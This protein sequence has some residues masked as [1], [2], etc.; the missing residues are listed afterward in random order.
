MQPV[1]SNNQIDFAWSGMIEADAH[2]ITLL[3]D[4]SY[5]VAKDRFDVSIK[6]T[7]D[8]SSEIGAPHLDE[9]A[10]GHA[11]E[12]VNRE[13]AGFTTIPVN[14]AHL[15]DLITQLFN[16]T[17]Q[18]HFIGDVV[19]NSP[20]VDRITATPKMRRLL[21]E[22]HFVTAF[23]Q[24]IC[25]RRAGDAGPID[26]NS[27]TYLG[28]IQLKSNGISVLLWDSENIGLRASFERTTKSA[29]GARKGSTSIPG[30]LAENAFAS[31]LYDAPAREVYQLTFPSV[32]APA[33]RIDSR[34]GPRYTASWP[35]M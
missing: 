11:A 9:A 20:E 17:E 5:R 6:R 1:R 2:A 10:V 26:G 24:P 34:S 32:L 22:Q 31:S 12:N 3:L 29:P 15:P 4:L 21:D 14:V 25:E 33:Y 7:E 13:A 16:S 30:Y 23:P 28:R 18:A 19:A 35:R 8:R 27:H